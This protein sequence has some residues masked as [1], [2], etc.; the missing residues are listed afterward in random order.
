MPTGLFDLNKSLATDIV[1]AA[2]EHCPAKRSPELHGL[3]QQRKILVREL[4]LQGLGRCRHHDAPAG[5]NC[6]NEVRKRLSRTGP[7]GHGGDGDMTEVDGLACACPILLR[8][9]GGEAPGHRLRHHLL[10]GA[11]LTARQLRHY[12]CQLV[13]DGRCGHGRDA[14]EYP[15]PVATTPVDQRTL[16]PKRARTGLSGLRQHTVELRGTL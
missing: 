12:A 14:S 3:G 2:L 13:G 1:P 7:S 4:V 5:E 11:D 16:C 10:T 6:G 8:L 15:V 9:H